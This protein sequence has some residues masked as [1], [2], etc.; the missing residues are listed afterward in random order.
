MYVCLCPGGLRPKRFNSPGATGRSS[1][2]PGTQFVHPQRPTG[3]SDNSFIKTRSK[4]LSV[5]AGF[6]RSASAT[7]IDCPRVGLGKSLG[8][9]RGTRGCR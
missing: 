5:C 3:K 2:T 1:W 4:N 8:R 9:I 6:A 7:S